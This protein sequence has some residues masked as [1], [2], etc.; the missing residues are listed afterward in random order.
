MVLNEAGQLTGRRGISFWGSDKLGLG[1]EK[2]LLID[3]QPL[4]A[5][6]SELVEK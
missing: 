4:L 5:L 6:H 3:S 2:S 1:L